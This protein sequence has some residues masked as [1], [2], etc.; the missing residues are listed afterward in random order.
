MMRLA[1]IW[2]RTARETVAAIH[3][4]RQAPSMAVERAPVITIE[5]SLGA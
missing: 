1:D 4:M 5:V 2:S 3:R